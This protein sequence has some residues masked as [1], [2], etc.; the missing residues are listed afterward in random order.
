[1]PDQTGSD[2][3][4]DVQES[5]FKQDEPAQK[6]NEP[7]TYWQRMGLWMVGEGE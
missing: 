3:D 7:L 5:L 2:S 4:L 1:M 6:V